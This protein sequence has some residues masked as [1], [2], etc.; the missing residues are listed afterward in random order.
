V[1]S[2]EAIQWVKSVKRSGGTG[3]AYDDLNC[4]G[5][6]PQKLHWRNSIGQTA[7][8][9]PKVGEIILLFQTVN[10]RPY[11]NVVRLT[12]LVS[13]VS[14]KVLIDPNNKDFKWYREVRLVAKAKPIH[15][16]PKPAVLNFG[17]VGN[18][19]LTFSID[20]LTNE[21]ISTREVQDLIWDLFIDFCCLDDSDPIV[22][23]S[24]LL[25]FAG[26]K[27]GDKRIMRHIEQELRYRN[28]DLVRM[29]K[30]Q[31]LVEGNG[32]IKCEC[33]EFDFLKTYGEVGEGFIECH[34]KISLHHGERITKP[35]DLALLCSNCHRILHRRN[36]DNAYYSVEELRH[37][38]IRRR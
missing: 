11:R 35:E 37:L 14:E 32:R 9:H 3:W 1:F 8:K 28:M 20:L 7:A 31:A 4:F 13:P 12:H 10:Y 30:E 29:K 19:G 25:D 17:K 21:K 38:I 18:G 23:N 22:V 15:I 2:S 16:I 24:S 6:E 34:H 33:C 36:P 27:E 5:N 26:A